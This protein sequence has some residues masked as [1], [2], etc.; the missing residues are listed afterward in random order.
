MAE[1]Q[2]GAATEQSEPASASVSAGKHGP[3][4]R[5]GR[6]G[7][8]RVRP[9]TAVHVPRQRGGPKRARPAAAETAVAEPPAQQEAKAVEQPVAEE[10]QITVRAAKR[11]DPVP[12]P[13]P[14]ELPAIEGLTFLDMQAPEHAADDEAEEQ[15][16]PART[17]MIP[18]AD[19]PVA[20]AEPDAEDASHT[21]TLLVLFLCTLVGGAGAI[22]YFLSTQEVNPLEGLF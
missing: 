19:R 21:K 5:S 18:L 9:Q 7:V 6:K 2:A 11:P 16:A 1:E 22:A 10:E 17:A 8:P 15:S 3:R 14:P 12:L 20:A 4:V 13:T